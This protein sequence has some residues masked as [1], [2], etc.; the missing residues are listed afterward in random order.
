M[1]KL[2]ETKRQGGY[3]LVGETLEILADSYKYI[4]A[5]LK[6]LNLQAGTCVI[7]DLKTEGGCLRDSIVFVEG[8]HSDHTGLH[9]LS[10]HNNNVIA[11]GLFDGSVLVGITKEYH[12][13]TVTNFV[14]TFE[15]A[16]EFGRVKLWAEA[17]PG[18][19]YRF[20]RLDQAIYDRTMQLSEV[21]FLTNSV[22]VG[23]F[24]QIEFDSNNEINENHKL[25]SLNIMGNFKNVLRIINNEQCFVQLK[26][27]GS[28]ASGY[29]VIKLPEAFKINAQLPLDILPKG[30]TLLGGVR[31]AYLRGRYIVWSSDTASSEKYLSFSYFK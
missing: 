3:P 18:N 29:V 12:K 20:M 11:Q 13:I 30:I 19:I 16:Y 8:H 31:P 23:L 28:N 17:P 26:F 6:G 7:L 2:L 10:P 27:M 15:E 4:E 14:G 22:E 5:I 1:N 25:Y 9:I 24:S 21:N